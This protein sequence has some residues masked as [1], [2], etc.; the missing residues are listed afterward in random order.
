VGVI[1]A[2]I[3]DRRGALRRRAVEIE[4]THFP[5]LGDVVANPF[6]PMDDMRGSRTPTAM[7]VATAASKALPPSSRMRMP[8]IEAS[9]SSEVT[10]AWRPLIRGRSRSWAFTGVVGQTI[11]TTNIARR[12]RNTIF[13]PSTLADVPR[14][15]DSAKS[16]PCQRHPAR[17]TTH[18][19][20]QSMYGH[21]SFL[22]ISPETPPYA[23]VH[24]VGTNP[25]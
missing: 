18:T 1:L 2:L 15:Q 20:A 6:P 7:A 25:I 13:A 3:G 21:T 11:D 19:V 12:A 4:S 9:G 5:C 16:A 10:T 14:C 22:D 23:D 8:A 17:R 24:S